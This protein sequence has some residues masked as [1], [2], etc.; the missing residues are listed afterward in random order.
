MSHTQPN[1]KPDFE[2]PPRPH[3]VPSTIPPVVPQQGHYP[4]LPPYPIMGQLPPGGF[5]PAFPYC[6]PPYGPPLQVHVVAMATIKHWG[7][8]IGPYSNTMECTKLN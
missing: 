6:Q 4:T 3:R 1:N 2:P 7:R 5:P 8:G